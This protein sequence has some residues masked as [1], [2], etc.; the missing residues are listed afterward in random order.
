MPLTGNYKATEENISSV[1]K[2]TYSTILTWTDYHD[3][4]V[5]NSTGSTYLDTMFNLANLLISLILF[6]F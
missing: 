6:M 3:Y 1:M 2:A 5:H 4:C